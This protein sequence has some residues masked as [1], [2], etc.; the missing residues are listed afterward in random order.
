MRV[1]S[2]SYDDD[3]D[4]KGYYIDLGSE[5][6]ESQNLRNL[7]FSKSLDVARLRSKVFAIKYNTNIIIEQQ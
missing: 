4:G 7:G 6:L 3:I 1:I 5:T 2:I